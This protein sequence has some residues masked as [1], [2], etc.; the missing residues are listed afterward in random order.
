MQNK[1]VVNGLKIEIAMICY[2]L[3]TIFK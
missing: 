1:T 3:S 2:L